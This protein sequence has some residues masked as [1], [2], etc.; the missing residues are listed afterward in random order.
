MQSHKPTIAELQDLALQLPE[1]I[2]Y[3]KM[4]VLFGSRATGNTHVNSDWDFA[5]F[6]DEEQRQAEIK[7]NIGRLFELPMLIG[8]VLNINADHIDIVELNHCSE[9]IAHFVA[10]DGQ[11]LY[12]N[13]VKGFEKFKQKVL[14]SNSDIKKIEHTKRKNI[15]QFLARWGV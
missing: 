6:C 5:V 2:P 4:L 13:E 9:L 7:D 8:E 12:E 14:L 1:K 11:V 3:L 15:E 10:R